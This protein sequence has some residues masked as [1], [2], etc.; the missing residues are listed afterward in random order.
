[1]N[2]PD[3]NLNVFQFE[4]VEL[5]KFWLNYFSVVSLSDHKCTFLELSVLGK[6]LKFCLT[7]PKYCH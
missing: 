2:V 5:N 1:M 3:D 4:N 7:P 6:E